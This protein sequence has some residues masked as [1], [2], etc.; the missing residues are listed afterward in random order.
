MEENN[1]IVIPTIQR[2]VIT[3]QLATGETSRTVSLNLSQP[4]NAVKMITGAIVAP[5][6]IAGEVLAIISCNEL[7]SPLGVVHEIYDDGSN[8]ILTC[9]N[10]GWQKFSKPVSGFITLHYNLI[11][12]SAFS[13]QPTILLELEFL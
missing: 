6:I 10:R 3:Y 5:A 8:N 4:A 12:G 7:S 11:D 1:K 2:A 9:M 13:G